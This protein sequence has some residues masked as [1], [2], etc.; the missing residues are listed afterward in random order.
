LWYHLKS[1]ICAQSLC[2]KNCETP[3]TQ[4]NDTKKGGVREERYAYC[5][6]KLRR[7]VGVETWIWL[8]IVTSQKAHTKYKWPPHATEWRPQW[9]F[10]AYTTANQHENFDLK[11]RNWKQFPSISSKFKTNTTQISKSDVSE[12]LYYTFSSVH[13]KAPWCDNDKSTSTAIPVKLTVIARNG[14][15]LREYIP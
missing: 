12:S 7:N 2:F 1:W 9:K 11:G 15:I 13:L 14:L 8:Q 4:C 10:S 6:N 5:I 3:C